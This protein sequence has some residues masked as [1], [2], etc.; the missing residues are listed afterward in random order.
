MVSTT[1]RIARFGLKV[2]PAQ[3]FEA[4]KK[5]LNAK[6]SVCSGTGNCWAAT[7]NAFKVNGPRD[8]GQ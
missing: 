5:S 7:I 2:E 3:L 8:G 1:P 6:N 4:G